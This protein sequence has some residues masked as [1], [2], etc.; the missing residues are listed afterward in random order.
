MNIKVDYQWQIGIPFFVVVLINVI[1]YSGQQCV[2]TVI[3]FK[4]KFGVSFSFIF[5]APRFKDLLLLVM[6]C[7]RF[8]K[9][10]P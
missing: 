3:V 5:S 1:I 6:F 4:W 2:Q 8:K 9:Q 7:P 10:S